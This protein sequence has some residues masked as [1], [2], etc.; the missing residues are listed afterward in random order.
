MQF[1]GPSGHGKSLLTKHLALAALQHGRLPIIA[2]AKEYDGD[3]IGD[4]R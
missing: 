1:I 2:S 4:A 3:L